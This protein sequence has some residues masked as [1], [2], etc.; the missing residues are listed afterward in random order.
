M[1]VV[2]DDDDVALLLSLP[3]SELNAALLEAAS[4]SAGI[5]MFMLMDGMFGI[6]DEAHALAAAIAPPPVDDG[7]AGM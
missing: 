1:C 2:V 6:A 7:E 4:G 3:I 5:F